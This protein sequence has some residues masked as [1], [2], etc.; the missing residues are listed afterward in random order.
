MEKLP[1]LPFI[2]P[3]VLKNPTEIGC[4]RDT[5]PDP[6]AWSRKSSVE[7]LTPPATT[8]SNCRADQGIVGDVEMPAL[9]SLDTSMNVHS[10]ESLLHPEALDSLDS[11][12]SD[13]HLRNQSL[14]PQEEDVTMV[15]IQSPHPEDDVA[16]EDNASVVRVE[17]KKSTPHPKEDDNP[18]VGVEPKE[19]SPQSQEDDNTVVGDLSRPSTPL[20]KMDD[21]IVVPVQSSDKFSDRQDDE[22]GDS[23]ADD[24]MGLLSDLSDMEEGDVEVPSKNGND[25]PQFSEV[26]GQ[27]GGSKC[28]VEHKEPESEYEPEGSTSDSSEDNEEGQAIMVPK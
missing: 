9:D 3:R 27:K 4:L 10:K 24:P 15:A 26:K 16:R 1:P 11:S 25:S 7:P 6:A 13:F 18:M 23:M 12:M 8:E 19:S 14:H 20:P 22:E 21:A 28:D 17:P 5:Q 2:D